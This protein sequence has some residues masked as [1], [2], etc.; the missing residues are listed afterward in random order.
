M[1]SAWEVEFPDVTCYDLT[2]HPKSFTPHDSDYVKLFTI[3]YNE[4]T[5]ILT[6]IGS[7]AL[8]SYR[9]MRLFKNRL[10]D[11]GTQQIN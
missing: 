10:H 6:Q 4:G 11:F 5:K 1:N 3:S 2:M 7:Q 8:P 9:A